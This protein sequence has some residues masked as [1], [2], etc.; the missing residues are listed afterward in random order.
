MIYEK[1]NNG[2]AYAKLNQLRVGQMV[3][4]DGGFNCIPAGKKRKVK[5]H[6]GELCIDCYNEK[7]MLYGQ[8]QEDHNT[9]TGIYPDYKKNHGFSQDQELETEF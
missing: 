5:T 9:L 6:E 8:L 4:V 1:D 2:R 3:Q 7:H